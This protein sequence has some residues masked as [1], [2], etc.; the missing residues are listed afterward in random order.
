MLRSPQNGLSMRVLT[1]E[2]A[3]QFYD[4]AKMAVPVAGHDGARYG[5]FSGLC[6]EP[7][8]APDAANRRHFPSVVLRPGQTYR[9][10]VEYRFDLER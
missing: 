3:L 2:P 10:I 9:Q 5:A 1:S 4:A 6:L 8:C 7:Q